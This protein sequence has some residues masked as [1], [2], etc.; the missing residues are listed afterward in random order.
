MGDV[1]TTTHRSRVVYRRD[2]AGEQALL[3]HLTACRSSTFPRLK[4]GVTLSAYVS[5][6][7]K[8]AVCFE[9]WHGT[10]LVGLVAAY[11]NDASSCSAFVTSVSVH[12][13]WMGRG[14][15]THLM[16]M[17]V[18]DA[19]A[20]GMQIVTLDVDRK[21]APAIALYHGLGFEVQDAV[22]ESCSMTF[23]VEAR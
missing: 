16:E 12:P 3:L 11:M 4:H 19:K 21:N 14:I 23:Q 10:A 8:L 17:C 13:E 2:T 1:T 22:G 6:L 15:A 9:A 18:E 5:K 7:R 20:R